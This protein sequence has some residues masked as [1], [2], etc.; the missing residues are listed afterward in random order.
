MKDKIK[1]FAVLGHPI[2]HSLSPQIHFLFAKEFSINLEYKKFDIKE[3]NLLE[4]I[5]S[6]KDEG[7]FGL[8]ITLPLKYSVFQ[9][10]DELSERASFCKSVNTITFL[11]NKIIGDSTDGRGLISDLKN[12]NVL[13]KGI[14]ILLIGAGGAANGGIY[15]LIQSRPE[16][17]YIINRTYTKAIEMKKYW[18]L[19]AKKNQVSLEVIDLNF[20]FSKNLSSQYNFDLIINATS[21]SLTSQDSPIP[22][23]TFNFLNKN[24]NCYDMMYGSE[25]PFMRDAYKKTDLVYDGIGM[26][27]E[28]AATSFNIWHQLQP[29][30]KNI[31]V[32]LKDL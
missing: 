16:K 7:Y 18:E 25:T 30:T 20:L 1:K 9:I 14:S 12:K 15:D 3:N 8:N 27:I 6:L 2:S 23:N 22:E 13:I 24:G 11:K 31:E 32:A 26:L 21:S 28:Q 4:R 19:F 29:S 10:C 17:I 5:E